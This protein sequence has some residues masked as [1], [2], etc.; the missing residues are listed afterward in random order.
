MNKNKIIEDIS[1]RQ[2]D[3]WAQVETLYSEAIKKNY[4][5][6]Q[7]FDLKA[8]P[9]V[10]ELPVNCWVEISRLVGLLT[11]LESF[12]EKIKAHK[13]VSGKPESEE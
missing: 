10:A 2:N 9:S 4:S 11:E 6:R 5:A 8:I 3:L 1:A 12:K 13:R 7:S